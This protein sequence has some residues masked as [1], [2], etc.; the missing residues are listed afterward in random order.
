M[1]LSELVVALGNHLGIDDFNLQANG[2]ASVRIA[3]KIEVTTEQY[4]DSQE[5]CLIYAYLDRVPET[6]LTALYREML[7]A[8]LFGA[9]TS[10]ATLCLDGE[11]ERL[12]VYRKLS[13]TDV[14]PDEFIDIWTR[15]VGVASHW[16]ERLGGDSQPQA[17]GEEEDPAKQWVSV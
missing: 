14:D 5:V 15:V 16:S 6:D 2:T 1:H 3:D 17:T 9:M 4:A 13:L 12:V 7:Q 10:D 8:N 11:S